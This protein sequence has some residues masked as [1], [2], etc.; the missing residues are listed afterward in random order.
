MEV[1]DEFKYKGLLAELEG[2]K[3]TKKPIHDFIKKVYELSN[4]LRMVTRDY[5]SQPQTAVNA[6][7]LVSKAL[8]YDASSKPIRYSITRDLE[9]L[10]N[11]IISKPLVTVDNVLEVFEFWQNK[12]SVSPDSI[13]QLVELLPIAE[14]LGPDRIHIS[15]YNIKEVALAYQDERLTQLYLNNLFGSDNVISKRLSQ[16]YPITQ[17]DKDKL[18]EKTKHILHVYNTI[19]KELDEHNSTSSEEH[20]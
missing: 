20:Y 19:L 11:Q 17:A 18:L 5:T 15:T 2:I 1:I 13:K 6:F 8:V 7:R 14:K 16:S 4:E 3:G 10:A 9:Y 12:L